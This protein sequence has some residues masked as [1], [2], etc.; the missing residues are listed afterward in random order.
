MIAKL[1]GKKLGMTQV[2]DAQ[3]VL[4]PVTVVKPDPVPGGPNQDH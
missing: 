4:V 1:L 3:N 2:Y